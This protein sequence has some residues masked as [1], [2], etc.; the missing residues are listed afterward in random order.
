MDVTGFDYSLPDELIAKKPLKERDAS[1]LLY[2]GMDDLVDQHISD[3]AKL[4]QP[5]DLWVL[6]DTRVIPARLLGKKQSGGK[7]ELLLLE[8]T[9]ESNVWI[10]WGKSNKP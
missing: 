5:G 1:R 4:V 6:N 2:V 9:A 8:P 3:L 10:A 7:V